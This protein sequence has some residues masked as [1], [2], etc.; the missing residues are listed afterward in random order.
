MVIMKRIGKKE[1]Y[2]RIMDIAKDIAYKKEGSMFIMAPKEKLKSKYE[3]L[4][5]QVL[6]RHSISE[7]G[8]HEILVRLAELDGAFLVSDDG[9][10]FAM[11][12]RIKKSISLPGFGTRH[13]AAAGLTSE[14]PEAVAIL[15]S[16]KTGWIRVF[17]EG[18]IALETNASKNPTSFTQKLVALL[19]DGDTALV[20]AAGVSAAIIGSWIPIIVVAGTYLAIKTATGIIKKNFEE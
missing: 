18:R 17:Q 11:G 16:E 12:A 15:V 6:S 19:T 10:L 14:V 9:E 13:A 3:L 5:P 1:T 7:H 8:M 4:F 2:N 20:V